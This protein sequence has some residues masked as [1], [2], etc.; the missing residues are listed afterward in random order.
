MIDF[1]LAYYAWWLN[2]WM[3]HPVTFCFAFCVPLAVTFWPWI[4]RR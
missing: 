1:L 4:W 3:A 2:Y